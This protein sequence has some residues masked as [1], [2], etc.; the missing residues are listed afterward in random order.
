MGTSIKEPQYYSR[1]I[2]EKKDPGRYILIIF[3][4]FSWFSLFGLPIKISVYSNATESH[5]SVISQLRVR[6]AG[7]KVY[8]K[9]QSGDLRSR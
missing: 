8:L 5:A 6:G 2:T 7:F 1:N 3:R 4:I 9:G